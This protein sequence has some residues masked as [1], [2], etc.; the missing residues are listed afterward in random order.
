MK[1]RKINHTEMGVDGV[2]VFA[3]FD[4]FIVGFG[5]HRLNV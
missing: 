4:C 3:G 1:K 2:F 5:A